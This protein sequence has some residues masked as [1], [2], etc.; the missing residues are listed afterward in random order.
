MIVGMQEGGVKSSQIIE[1]M[2]MPRSTMSTV[3]M[4]WRVLGCM[5]TQK[6]KPWPSKL[7]N[8]AQRDLGRLIH[9]DRRLTL[10]ALGE[11]FH[12]HCNIIR[13]HIRILGFGN[14]IA[15]RKPYLSAAHRTQ[16]LR[17]ARK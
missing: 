14:H 3:L 6:P 9:G 15:I 2:G 5:T 13:K 11:T 7:T 16:R 10:A 4:K 8:R 17:F 12:V 1:F